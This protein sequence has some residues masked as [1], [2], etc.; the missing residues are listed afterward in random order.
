MEMVTVTV[1]VLTEQMTEA[2]KMKTVMKM[3]VEMR[4]MILEETQRN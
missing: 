1:T 2:R 3:M 4:T